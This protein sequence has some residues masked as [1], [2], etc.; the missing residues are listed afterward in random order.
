MSADEPAAPR[1]PRRTRGARESLGSVV[2]GFES[3][4]VFLGG[5]VVYGLRVLP[6]GIEPWWGIVAGSVLAL[7]MV[8]IAGLLRHSWAIAVGWALQVV[9]LLGGFLVPALVVVAIIFGGMWAYATIKGASL[10]ARNARRAAPP[11]PSNGE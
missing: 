2:L 7:V 1:R 10:D 9:V 6:D 11:E 5:L 8:V 3:I 4:I